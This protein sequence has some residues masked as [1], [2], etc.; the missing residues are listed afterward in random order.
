VLLTHLSYK[1]HRSR[2]IIDYHSSKTGRVNH[3]YVAP[4]TG[5]NMTNRRVAVGFLLVFHIHRSS[6]SCRSQ[7]IIDF[8]PSNIKPEV[9]TA[10]MWRHTAE[11]S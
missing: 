1:S 8:Q 4:P 5:I 10:L 9:E 6:N 2:V 3:R 11:P 7:V